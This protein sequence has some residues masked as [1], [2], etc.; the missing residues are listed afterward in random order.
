[1]GHMIGKYGI[2]LFIGMKGAQYLTKYQNLKNINTCYNL[3]S[4][5]LSQA[6][7]EA[8]IADSLT[9]S[10][11]RTQ[12]LKNIKIHWDRQNKHIPGKHNFQVGKGR[13]TLKPSELEELIKKRVGTGQR[14]SGEFGE[15]GFVERVD[16]GKIIGEHAIEIDGQTKYI[17]TT[18]GIIKYAKDGQVHVIPSNPEAIIYD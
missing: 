7:K 3:E 13:I 2:D 16:F 11:K 1:M 17:P 5:L 6:N 18:K 12:Y 15:A 10:T 9:F 4:M 8:I 14:V